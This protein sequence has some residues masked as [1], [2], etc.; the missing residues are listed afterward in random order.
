MNLTFSGAVQE[1]NVPI[2]IL[3]DT[4]SELSEIF[5]AELVMVTSNVNTNVDPSQ[6]SITIIDDER[7]LLAT[8]TS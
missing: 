6:A 2:T 5:I 1:I 4:E 7:K 3:D 8:L